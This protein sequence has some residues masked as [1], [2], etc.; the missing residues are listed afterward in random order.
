MD[1]NYCNNNGDTAMLRAAYRG[2]LEMIK[3]LAELRKVDVN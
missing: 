3:Y 1:I 2:D